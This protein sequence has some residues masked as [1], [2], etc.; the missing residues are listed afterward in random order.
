MKSTPTLIVF[1]FL[2][3]ARAVAVE[4]PGI[5]HKDA[6]CLSCHADKV[7]GRSVHSAM[8]VACTVCHLMETRGDMTT[9]ELAMPKTRI[10]FSC[11]EESSGVR[12]HSPTVKGQ[13]LDCHAA[14]SS[15]RPLLLRAD[16]D[17]QAGPLRV[18]AQH[19]RPDPPLSRRR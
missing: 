18:A 5:L 14:H 19:R 4:H 16:V 1:L 7:N 3:S 15:S 6:N 17:I 12:E 8:A 2:L 9:T 13:C 10:C 11:H